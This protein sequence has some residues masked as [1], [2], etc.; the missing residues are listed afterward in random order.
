[1]AKF[2]RRAVVAAAVVTALLGGAFAWLDRQVHRETVTP[3]ETLNEGGTAGRALAVLSPGMS[4]FP[5]DVMAAFTSGLAESG[6]RIDRTTASSQATTA[7]GAYDLVV[8]ASPIYG[9]RVAPPL[10]DYIARVG[11]FGGRRVVAVI[12]AGGN[13]DDSVTNTET[14]IAGHN[15]TL[16][17]IIG[18]AVYEPNDPENR[19]QGSN[20][21]RAIAMAHDA[22][23]RLAGALQ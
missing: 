17:D 8:L 4:D 9:S 14:L 6:W 18:Y 10:Q 12:T 13:P 15:A 3:L 1:M 21:E 11:D 23:V 16:V 7:I 22:A 20:T 19:Y 5:A 2:L